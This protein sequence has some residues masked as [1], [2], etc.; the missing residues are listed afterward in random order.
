MSEKIILGN[1]IT[2]DENMP[3]AEA[4]AVKDGIIVKAGNEAEARAAV[5][6]SAEV[7]D[8]SGQWVYPGFMDAHTHG[9]FAGLRA[10]GQADLSHVYPVDYDKYAEIIK[11]FIKDNPQKEIYVAAGW[12]ED[13]THVDYKYLD[14]ICSDKP[15]I[16]NTTGGHSC[17]LNSKALEK[18]GF[19]DSSVEKFGTDLVHVGPDGHPNGYICEGPAIKLI[20]DLPN[21]LEDVKEYILGWQEMALS[22]GLTA[23]GDAGVELMSPLVNEAYKELQ[24][25]GKLLM[26]TYG[27][28]MTVDHPEN[29]TA[30]SERIAKMAKELN[31]EYYK[32]VGIKAFLD[33]VIEAHTGWLLEDYSDQPGYRG[34]ERFNNPDKMV[35]LLVS[36]QKN[37]LSVHVHTDGDGSTRFMLDCIK[38]AQEITGDKDQRNV[39]AHLH[40]VSPED[41]KKMADTCSIAAVAPLWTM[42]IAGVCDQEIAY[43]GQERFDNNYPIKSFVDAGATIVFHSDYPISQNYDIPL[44]IFMANT[45][46]VTAFGLDKFEET[47]HNTKEGINCTDALKACTINVA[48]TWRQEDRLGSITPGKVANFAVV[49][50]DFIDGDIMQFP[51][52]KIIA[53]IVDGNVVYK[54]K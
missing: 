33:G 34:V 21:T 49:D 11:Q 8:Y 22:H 27:Y 37:G 28:L 15:L 17:L 48:Y 31:G 23:V 35:E 24:D 39:L 4:V 42:A 12:T 13:G 18:F 46:G 9:M 32:V 6:S 54:N 3:K 5:S 7:L 50:A 2:V 47:R 1:I 51:E 19:D 44:S 29:P 36:A 41:I 14:G 40:L 26:R 52:A 16:M 25:E 20:G 43:I 30:E 10:V 45:R 38:K 53:T